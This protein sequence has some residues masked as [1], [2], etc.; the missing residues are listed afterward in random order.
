M[1]D[2]G[3]PHDHRVCVR[4]VVSARPPG[5]SKRAR[6]QRGVGVDIFHLPLV[7]APLMDS[8][9]T[10]PLSDRGGRPRWPAARSN[11]ALTHRPEICLGRPGKI[12]TA[13]VVAQDGRR[14]AAR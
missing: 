1:G 9:G 6:D 11:P 8:A 2:P 14:R 3:A 10:G 5:V 12:P 13:K 4:R 7:Y